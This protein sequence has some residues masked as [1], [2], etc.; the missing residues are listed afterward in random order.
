MAFTRPRRRSA[1]GLFL[2]SVF[3]GLL[4]GAGLWLSVHAL[5]LWELLPP[6]TAA[7]ALLPI[8]ASPT[9]EPPV[10]AAPPSGMLVRQETVHTIIPDRPRLEVITYTVQAGDTV[11][12][13]ADRFSITP[14]TIMW[15]NGDLEHN[16]DM[17]GIGQDLI[18]L[19][20]SGVYHKVAAGETVES[21]ATRFK[22]EPEAITAYALNNLSEPYALTAGQMLVVPGGE[23]PY[24]PRRVSQ[25]AGAVPSDARRGSGAFGWP[26]SGYIT[27]KYWNLHRALDV[28]APVGTP[29]VASDSGYVT[30]AGWDSSGYGNLIIIDHGN[31]YVTLYAHLSA[32]QVKT[33]DSVGKGGRIGSVGSTGNSTGPHLHFEIRYH[34]VQ[35]NPAGF[36]P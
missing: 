17:L 16:P 6:V 32:F 22:V 35:R 19:P 30:Y 24:V 15:S 21:L 9:P 8:A 12:G 11:F 3:V 25:Y 23:K 33:G 26:A 2:L 1:G 13:I 34:D 20:V 28:G 5:P 4:A 36:L 27:Q 7:A 29:V 10:Y 14:E 18:I 31:G